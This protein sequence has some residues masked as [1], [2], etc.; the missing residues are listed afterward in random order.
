MLAP[1][2]ARRVRSAG[3]EWRDVDESMLDTTRPYRVSLPSGRS[4]AVFFYD[5]PLSRAVAFENILRS[6]AKSLP[7]RLVTSC[8]R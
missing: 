2:Q 7:H 5:G 8:R 3:G 6:A 4:I 1:R